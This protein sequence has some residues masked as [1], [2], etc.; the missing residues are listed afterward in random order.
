[1][2]L[3]NAVGKIPFWI[4][5]AFVVA[6]F[7]ILLVMSGPVIFNHAGFFL[8]LLFLLFFDRIVAR[9]E[10]KSVYVEDVIEAVQLEGGRLR[11]LGESIEA[12]QVQRIAIGSNGEQ[13]YL[14]FPFNPKF[15]VRLLFPA[16]QVGQ[17]SLHLKRLLP[18]I[19]LV[20]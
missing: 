10:H 13:G 19:I 15:R 12:S 18:D 2:W 3:A 7:S 4:R 11:I 5:V 20:E 6:V 14:Q 1:M 8:V 17:L 16:D 9:T